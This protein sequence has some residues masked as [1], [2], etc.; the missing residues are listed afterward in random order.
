MRVSTMTSLRRELLGLTAALAN[1]LAVVEKKELPKFRFDGERITTAEEL[2]VAMGISVIEAKARI[3]HVRTPEGVRKYGQPIGSVITTD[4]LP[5][6]DMNFVPGRA[7]KWRDHNGVSELQDDDRFEATIELQPGSRLRYQLTMVDKKTGVSETY[8]YLSS[9]AYAIRSFE[10]NRDRIRSK[11]DIRRVK[12]NTK[13]RFADKESWGTYGKDWWYGSED[14]N[15][16]PDWE[17]NNLVD[18]QNIALHA[19][20]QLGMNLSQPSSVPFDMHPKYHETFNEY[21][22]SL[23]DSY[24]GITNWLTDYGTAV[25]QNALAYNT[26]VTKKHPDGKFDV[27]GD[28]TTGVYF[29]PNLFG[30]NAREKASSVKD[31]GQEGTNWWSNRW[32]TLKKYDHLDD[33][34]RNFLVTAVHEVGHTIARITSFSELWGLDTRADMSHEDKMYYRQMFWWDAS[35][36]MENHGLGKADDIYQAMA[37]ES[38][39]KEGVSLSSHTMQYVLS[40]YGATNLHE[41]LAEVWAEYDLDPEPRSF[42]AEMGQVMEKVLDEWIY[43]N[44]EEK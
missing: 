1:T 20:A 40:K 30:V 29:N 32:S 38:G 2:A 6:A 41:M 43:W 13:K 14:E 16:L 22:M 24:P 12:P 31:I 36:I 17:E 27:F 18:R 21:V 28:K 10:F 9:R 23:E 33:Q 7:S 25:Y 44:T 4:L 19:S 3:R 34:Q 37:E 42:A 35:T 15:D 11:D 39:G 8:S 26:V 5:H